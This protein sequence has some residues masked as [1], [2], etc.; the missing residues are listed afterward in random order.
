MKAFLSHSSKDK[1]FVGQVFDKLGDAQAEYDEKTFEPTLNVQTI[2]NAIKRCG[3]FVVFLSKD[4]TSSPY[5]KEEQ[6]AALESLGQGT[7]RRV[8]VIAIDDTSYKSLPLWLREINVLQKISNPRLAVSRIQA[9]L[10]SIE[11]ES[12]S[13]DNVFVNREDELQ[14]LRKSLSAP[15]GEAPVALHV[16]GYH[17]IGRRTLMRQCLKLLFPRIDTPIEISMASFEGAEE[18]YRQLFELHR[19]SSLAEKISE[20]T[21]FAG[22]DELE[23]AE[24]LASMLFEMAAKNDFIII[25]DEGGVLSDDGDYQPYFG[26]MVERL[27][28]LS[29]PILGIVQ[30]RRMKLS[31]QLDHK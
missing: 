26:K 29:R 21:H 11:T 25:N 5:V 16:S 8:L 15:P 6:R 19:V 12:S 1:W 27:S 18:L 9:T 2:R 13:T 7:L 10:V 30:T 23:K 17:G 3:L 31:K 24:H 28:M 4:S 20:I 22:L 14:K